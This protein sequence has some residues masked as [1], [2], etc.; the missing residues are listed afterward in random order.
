MHWILQ[1]NIFSETGWDTLVET[2]TRFNIPFSE[3]KVVPFIGELDP[4]PKLDTKNVICFGSYAMRHIAKR[5]GWNPGVFDLEPITFMEQRKHWGDMMLNHDCEVLPYKD[6]KITTPMFMRPT[7]DSKHFAG[8]LFDPEEF[9]DFQTKMLSTGEDDYRFSVLPDTLI[10]VCKPRRI[11]GEA[12]FWVVGT[13]I[14]TQSMYKVG[15]RVVYN[16]NVDKRYVDF[17]K[18]VVGSEFIA[19][20]NWRTRGTA[21]W[22]PHEAFVFDVAETEEGMKIVE[23]NTINS[24]GFYAADIQKLVF[25][26]EGKFST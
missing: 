23:I 18:A 19:A 6:I 21:K 25:A 12:R 4:M 10:Q 13:E 24:S 11:M 16:P 1:N 17:A 14:V 3:H 9:H 8:K 5:E 7:D 26:L 2:L 22:R 20:P 15:D